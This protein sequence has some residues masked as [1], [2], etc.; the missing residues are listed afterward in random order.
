MIPDLKDK[1]VVFEIIM[2]PQP[3]DILK[4]TVR[5]GSATCPCCG[6]TTPADRTRAQFI[7]RHGGASD[8]RLIAVVTKQSG[9]AGR[10]YRPGT[11][12]DLKAV[13][14]AREKCNT[15]ESNVIVAHEMFPDEPLPY[16][17]SIFNIHL[18]DARQWKDLFSQRQL[19]AISTLCSVHRKAQKQ[20]Y[21]DNDRDFADAITTCLALAIDRQADYSTSLCRWISQREII[22]NTFGRPALGIIWNFAEVCPL[23]G[24]SGSFEGAYSWIA[25]VCEYIAQSYPVPG[26]VEQISATE[27]LLPDDSAS[28]F[29]TDP[30]YYDAVPYANLSDFFYV[31]LRRILNDVHPSLFT[32]DLTPK[33]KEI[34]QLAERNPT[35]SYKTKENFEI[36]MREALMEGR[37]TTTP[38]GIGVIF[39]AH[40]TTS[41]WETM[42]QAVIDAG[43]VIVASWPIHTEFVARLRAINSATLSSSIHLVCRP[44]ENPDG[45]VQHDEVGTWSDVLAELPKRIHKWLP[46]LASVGIVGA[47]AIFSCLGPALEIYSQY[48]R[49]ERA[50]GEVVTLKDY[51]VEVWAVVSHE[52]LSMIFESTDATGFEEDA[53]L[54]AMWLWTLSNAMNSNDK[55]IFESEEAEAEEESKDLKINGFVLEYDAARKI[56][57]GLGVHLDNLITLVEVKGENARLLP[58]AERSRYLFG[59]EVK[60]K[61]KQKHKKKGGQQITLDGLT[62]VPEEDIS[63]SDLA[64]F[65]AGST[66][67]DRLHQAMLL[68]A[69]GRGDA[70]KRFI[71]D[72][73]AQ[74]Q[75]VWSL[76][77]A[78][79]AL[80]PAGSEE[81]RWVEGVL[82]RKKSL[83]L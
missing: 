1:K 53:R 69:E 49:V 42:L 77:Q 18:L 70:L 33:K 43:W 28:I 50:S 31:W 72:D 52:A 34:C 65:N 83:G 25:D 81:R 36:L 22:G 9:K 3:A 66:V 71:V 67:L 54:T 13:K 16:L 6:Y 48:S 76:A 8:A 35:Y 24:G 11:E 63:S 57:Q 64:V 79:S 44:R 5:R 78:L 39:F 41:A 21:K 45:S 15:V 37:R 55:S 82:T 62:T 23:S 20:I 61:P 74:D 32:E 58:V 59:H 14:L 29:I 80:Y 30:P 56:A 40:K 68:F 46:S 73:L 17:R 2:N 38:E 10:S 47:D 60:S 26:Q 7:G 75:G 19:V 51:L 12:N 4:G 27:Y